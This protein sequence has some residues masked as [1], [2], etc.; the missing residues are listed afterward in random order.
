ME[1]DNGG[2]AFPSVTENYGVGT[3]GAERG[4][5]LRDYFAGQVISQ[6]QITVTRQEPA[7]ADPALVAAYAH[8]YA[9]TAYAIADAMLA[10]RKK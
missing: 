9:K 10:E 3:E 7:E 6:C 8:R 2:P 1:R 5:D 4:M